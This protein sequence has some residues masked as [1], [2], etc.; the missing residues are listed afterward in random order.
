MGS[1]FKPYL[2]V[3]VDNLFLILSKAGVACFLG[4]NFV[5]ALAYAD[6]IVLLAPTI[7]ENYA[8]D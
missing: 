2:C 7:C 4:P 3:Y 5:G 1:S 8:Q 6:D